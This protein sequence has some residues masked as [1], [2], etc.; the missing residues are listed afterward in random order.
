MRLLVSRPTGIH[1]ATV[2]IAFAR[3]VLPKV[4]TAIYVIVRLDNRVAAGQFVRRAEHDA[5][6]QIVRRERQ[7]AEAD[8]PHHV[9]EISQDGCGLLHADAAR[10]HQALAIFPPP[11]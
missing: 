3:D 4:S 10:L 7:I 2:K 5:H 1:H 8:P 9:G 6:Y 11:V